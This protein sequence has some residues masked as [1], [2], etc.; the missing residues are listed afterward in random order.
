MIHII[1][2]GPH[3]SPCSSFPS[4]HQT[5][6]SDGFPELLSR[7][8][9][10]DQDTLVLETLH[11]LPLS[12]FCCAE[13]PTSAPS[14]APLIML[15]LANPS[16]LPAIPTHFQF[17]DLPKD[18]YAVEGLLRMVHLPPVCPP[19]PCPTRLLSNSL[20]QEAFPTYLPPG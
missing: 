19:P 7:L 9:K 17:P 13:P 2:L 8:I 14:L 20:P 15:T 16:L 12:L 11:W 4:L 18:A 3:L 1:N 6:A 10:F 5:P